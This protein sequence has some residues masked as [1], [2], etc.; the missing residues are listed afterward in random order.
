MSKHLEFVGALLMAVGIT[1]AASAAN[2]VTTG[3]ATISVTNKS[4]TASDTTTSETPVVLVQTSVNFGGERLV[5]AR[6]T[7]E[8]RC[9]PTGEGPSVGFCIVD[10]VARNLANS[11]ET[12]LNP[13]V[14]D[15]FAFDA[16]SDPSSTEDKW[17][18][19]AME[20][21]I[22]LPAGDYAIRVYWYVADTGGAGGVS[23][24]LDDWHYRVEVAN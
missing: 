23:F 18:A 13:A 1:S 8:S 3:G 10:I 16:I 7:A 9:Q 21:S 11:E 2:V 15:D 22:R 14:N 19:H 20:R 6:F 24:R 12:A 4:N 5:T 17:E